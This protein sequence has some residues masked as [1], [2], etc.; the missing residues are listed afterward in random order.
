MTESKLK[1]NWKGSQFYTPGITDFQKNID[2]QEE[3]CR[4]ILNNYSKKTTKGTLITLSS[5]LTQKKLCKKNDAIFSIY[6]RNGIVPVTFF[7][8]SQLGTIQVLRH[9]DFDPF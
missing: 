8:N 6:G 2:L 9:H 3:Q 1:Q 7:L 5:R 4:P